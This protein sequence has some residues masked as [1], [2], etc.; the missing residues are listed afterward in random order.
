MS[1]YNA[2]LQGS[3][4]VGG[5]LYDWVGFTWLVFVSAI[6]TALVL[7]MVPYLRVPEIEARARAQATASAG[8]A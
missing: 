2:G 3:Q 4:V 6:T 5:Y 1:V 8:A 7:V